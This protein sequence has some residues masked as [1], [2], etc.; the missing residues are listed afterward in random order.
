MLDL[1]QLMVLSSFF[2]PTTPS[3]TGHHFSK[4]KSIRPT[5]GSVKQHPYYLRINDWSRRK[6]LYYQQRYIVLFTLFSRLV[7]SYWL[8][9]WLMS[10]SRR[11][12]CERQ[13]LP[14]RRDA[15]DWPSSCQTDQ[16]FDLRLHRT[17]IK[18]EELEELIRSFFV[19]I[20]FV[21]VCFFND[22]I[23]TVRT[24]RPTEERKKERRGQA[25]S[26][27]SSLM[28]MWWLLRKNKKCLA[29][30]SNDS[31]FW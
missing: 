29:I 7:P 12:D 26:S 14:T 1:F 20:W 21:F 23:S 16:T 10:T 31:L 28:L 18:Q 22:D 19:F 24:N 27:S 15:L 5:D 30:H 9:L 13:R 25:R 6:R 17:S 2:F 8:L 11:F 3:S 4:L